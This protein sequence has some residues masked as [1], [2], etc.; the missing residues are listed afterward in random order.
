MAFVHNTQL[1][2]YDCGYPRWTAFLTMPNAIFFY[3]LFNDFYK[4]SYK[5]QQAKLERNAAAKTNGT[6]KALKAG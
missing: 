4:H 5:A 2:F 3:Y 1:L 6:K